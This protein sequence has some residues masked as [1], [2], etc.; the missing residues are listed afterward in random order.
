LTFMSTSGLEQYHHTTEVGEHR[1]FSLPDGSTI[2]LNT[3]SE[4]K[5]TYDKDFRNIRLLRGEAH[6][7]VARD[8]DRPFLVYAGN[9]LV[10]AVGTAF[11]VFIHDP[12]EV[13]VTVTHGVIEVSALD[14]DTN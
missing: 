13:E 1:T 11:T 10:R 8:L 7:E 5:V 3:N 4:L 6:F 2:T 12:K 14:D 9:G